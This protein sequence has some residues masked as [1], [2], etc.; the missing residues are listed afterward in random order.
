MNEMK[1]NYSYPFRIYRKR[2]TRILKVVDKVLV[3]SPNE[4]SLPPT[5]TS[6]FCSLRGTSERRVNIMTP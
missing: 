5:V 3:V 1:L 2:V 6:I 4:I